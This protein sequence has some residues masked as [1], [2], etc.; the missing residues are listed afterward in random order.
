[1]VNKQKWGVIA[2]CVG[3]VLIILNAIAYIAGIRNSTFACSF[4][5]GIILCITG[6]LLHKKVGSQ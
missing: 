5:F 4:I 2:Y 1:M 6:M 3:L